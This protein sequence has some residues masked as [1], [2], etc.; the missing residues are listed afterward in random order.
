MAE[1]MPGEPLDPGG[2]HAC[3][4]PMSGFVDGEHT[5]RVVVA[6]L[7]QFPQC[8][9]GSSVQWNVQL[10]AGFTGRKMQHACL[11]VNLAPF[12]RELRLSSQACVESQIELRHVLRCQDVDFVVPGA[13][14]SF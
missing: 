9:E 10:A 12:E 5:R 3:V 13:T 8:A 2:L 14:W 1:T 6:I 7:V 11:P 4:K